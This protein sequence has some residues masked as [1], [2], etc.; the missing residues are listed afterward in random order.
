ML[1]LR[2]VSAGYDAGLVLR[3]VDLVVPD[4]TVVALIGANGAGKSTLLRVASGL[5]VPVRGSVRVDGIDVTGKA[6][7]QLSRLGVCHV[8]EGRGV[9]RGLTVEEN[10]RLQAGS[11]GADGIEIAIQAFPRLGQRLRQVAGSLSG[12]EQQML[13]LARAY[14]TSP[15]VVLLDEVSMGLAPK[16]VD[17]IFEHLRALARQGTALLIVE[18][19]VARA[20]DLA[21]VVY[22]LG[23]GQV[24]FVGE[25]Y[26][27]SHELVH[28]SYL[29]GLAS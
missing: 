17:E 27:L 25:P 20:L 28:G 8:P 19:Y 12:G 29:G 2:Q 23:R 14:L 7:Y 11:A 22:V 5:L 21:D 26:E 4:A 3:D 9:F 15:S 18:Q 6:P 13:S 16:I 1:E 10:L 24:Q